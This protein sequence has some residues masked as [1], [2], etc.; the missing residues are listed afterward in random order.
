MDEG[1]RMGVDEEEALVVI[2]VNSMALAN[3][4]HEGT[5]VVSGAE[6]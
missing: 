4:A 3:V 5:V 1:E 2:T 6:S